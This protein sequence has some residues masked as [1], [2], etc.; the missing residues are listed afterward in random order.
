MTARLLAAY[1]FAAAIALV[2]PPGGRGVLARRGLLPLRGLDATTMTAALGRLARHIGRTRRAADVRAAVIEACAALS[3][4]LRAGTPPGPA[5]ARVAVEQ[6]VVARAATAAA[7]GGD[8]ARALREAG[9]TPGAGGLVHLGAAWEVAERTGSGLA[10]AADRVADGL[11]EE[12]VL[13][14]EVAAQLSSA[15]ATA[16]LMAGLPVVG[17]MLGMSMGADPLGVL[18]GTPYGLAL[19]AAGLALTA[20]GL[21]WTSRLVRSVTDRL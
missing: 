11:R 4:E 16:R 12:A 5:L 19:L 15:R 18:L 8:V 6:P 7:L 21:W 2:V 10:A 17:I 3:A 14:H 1:C 9:A 20:C 13:R